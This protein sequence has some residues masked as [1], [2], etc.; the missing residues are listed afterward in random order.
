MA[1]SVKCGDAMER[2]LFF[3]IG[4]RPRG[5]AL[6]LASTAGMPAGAVSAHTPSGL[7]APQ[8]HYNVQGESRARKKNRCVSEHDATVTALLETTHY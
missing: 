4:W 3:L 7:R 8:A 2:G 5:M 6:Q 1:A